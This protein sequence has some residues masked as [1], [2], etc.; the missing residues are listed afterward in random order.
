MEDDGDWVKAGDRLEAAGG[1]S[2]GSGKQAWKE[3]EGAWVRGA[4]CAQQVEMEKEDNGEAF[5][6]VQAWIK[7]TLSRWCDRWYILHILLHSC[8]HLEEVCLKYTYCYAIILTFQLIV[9]ERFFHNAAAWK[10]SL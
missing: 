7:P 8:Q 5:W 3:C 6:P 2:R 4:W 9:M 10:V 1:R